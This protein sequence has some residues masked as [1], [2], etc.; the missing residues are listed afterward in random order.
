MKVI[1]VLGLC[2]LL[3]C[4]IF[5]TSGCQYFARARRTSYA[6]EHPELSSAQKDLLL[7]GRLWSGMSPEEVRASLGNP[8]SVSKDILGKAEVWTYIYRDQYTPHRKYLFER[9]LRLEFR[10]GRLANWR[11]D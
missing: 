3:S 2:F 5:T 9:A 7:K 8:R 1:R 11:E 6:R 10:E 4:F